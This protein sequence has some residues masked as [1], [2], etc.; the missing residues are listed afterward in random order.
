MSMIFYVC[1]AM[2]PINNIV[3]KRV[4]DLLTTLYVVNKDT[5]DKVISYAQT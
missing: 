4:F 5:V 1:V 3:S 2:Q